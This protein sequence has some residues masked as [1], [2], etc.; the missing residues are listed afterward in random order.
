MNTN[1]QKEGY[2]EESEKADAFWTRCLTL[3]KIN[4]LT[5]QGLSLKLGWNKRRIETL[6]SGH[7]LPPLL[8]AEL[9]AKELDTS[10]EYLLNGEIVSKSNVVGSFISELEDVISR[11]RS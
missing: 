2:F 6:V 4:H 3:M 5:Q 8:E 11:Y 7:R 1:N 10:M 9:L